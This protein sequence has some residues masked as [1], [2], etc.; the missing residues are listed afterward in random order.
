MSI[1]DVFL[2]PLDRP[3]VALVL[4]LLV[5]KS[6]LLCIAIVSP[7]A[8]YDTSTTLL[9]LDDQLANLTSKSGL[10][11]P[12]KLESLVR[13]DAIYFTQIAQNGYIWEQE[14]AFGWGFTRLIALISKGTSMS[15]TGE[16]PTYCL[17]Y[18]VLWIPEVNWHRNNRWDLDI[19]C[20]P[21]LFCS[22]A[23]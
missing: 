7:G 6:L 11:I 3:K 14:W 12:L 4:Y 18:Y 1:S 21:P 20:V 22:N 23:T 13:W 9:H 17:R 5:W 16:F 2:H 10:G 19:T 15:V 8:G